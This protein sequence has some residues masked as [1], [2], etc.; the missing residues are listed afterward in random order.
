MSIFSKLDIERHSVD[1]EIES[2]SFLAIDMIE[3]VRNLTLV[4]QSKNVEY[5]LDYILFDLENYF[6]HLLGKNVVLLKLVSSK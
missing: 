1:L 6:Y 3:L 2:E 4:N 5:R